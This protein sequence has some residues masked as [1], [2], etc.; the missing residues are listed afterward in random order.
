MQAHRWE[1]KQPHMD[2]S[3]GLWSKWIPGVCC[4]FELNTL[5]WSAM[6]DTDMQSTQTVGTNPIMNT[7]SSHYPLNQ[8][9]LVTEFKLFSRCSLIHPGVTPINSYIWFSRFLHRIPALTWPSRGSI[10]LP[11]LD[12]CCVNL[13]L[14]VWC[15]KYTAYVTTQKSCWDQIHPGTTFILQN[16]NCSSLAVSC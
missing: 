12:Q 10:S 13:A 16:Y 15:T 11:H 14:N 1:P 7:N 3:E 8:L 5:L 2:P 6:T 9:K 4:R